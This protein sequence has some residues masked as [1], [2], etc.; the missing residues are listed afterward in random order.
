MERLDLPIPAR[1]RDGEDR[2]AEIG[3]LLGG[4]FALAGGRGHKARQIDVEARIEITFDGLAVKRNKQNGG[5][6]DDHEGPY[7]R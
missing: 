5:N 2:I 4:G 1:E 6:G 7:R 3:G